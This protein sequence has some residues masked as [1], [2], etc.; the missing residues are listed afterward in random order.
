MKQGK[1]KKQC[2]IYCYENIINKKKYIGQSVNLAQRKRCFGKKYRYSGDLFQNAINKYG[3]ENFQ[4]SVLVYCN[5]EELNHYEQLYISQFK[6]NDREYGYNCTSGGD[7]QYFRTEDTKKKISNAWSE[8]R[9][10]KQSESQSG[11]KNG[12][13]GNKWNNEQKKRASNIRKKIAKETFFKLNGFDISELE[14]KISEYVSSKEKITK[15]EIINHFHISYT[16]LYSICKNN[17]SLKSEIDKKSQ[18]VIDTYKKVVVQC[19]LDNHDI[20]LNIFPSLSDAM[21]ITKM[22]SIKHC[23]YGKQQHAYGYF[24]RYGK[25]GE[26][27]LD[28]I[29][30]EYLKPTPLYGK[31]SKEGLKRLKKSKSTK[32]HK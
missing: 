26:E 24:W 2:G 18:M 11:E 21:R 7:S 5:P 9:R 14:D 19:E 27:P 28:K 32:K 30:E 6:T 4:Y 23:L 29:N 8:E 10:K 25:E 20:I 22:Q 16:R 15:Q 31:L 13:W 1:D 12:N 17:I 3:A